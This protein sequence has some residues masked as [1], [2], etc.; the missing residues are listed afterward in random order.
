[1]LISLLT[2]QMSLASVVSFRNVCFR[3]QEGC[4]LQ[5]PSGSGHGSCL[6]AAETSIVI[7]SAVRGLLKGD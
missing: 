5:L 4:L 6:Q 1:M 3:L 2:T 7:V